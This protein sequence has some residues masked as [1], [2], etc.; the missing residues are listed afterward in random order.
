MSI[1]SIK[2]LKPKTGSK[3]RYK[4]GYL[5]VKNMTKYVGPRPVI[6]RSSLEFMTM[7]KL[8]RNPDVLAWSSE[9]IVIPYLDSDRKQRNYHIDLVVRMRN[10]HTWIIEV[11]P[12]NQTYPGSYDWEKNSRKWIAAIEWCITKDKTYFAIFTENKMIPSNKLNLINS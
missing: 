4:Q 8:D 1:D 5:D 9:C 6:Y 2:H 10:G 12:E 11:K 3:S 7:I